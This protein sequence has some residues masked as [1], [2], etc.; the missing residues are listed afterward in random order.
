MPRFSYFP[1]SYYRRPTP[2]YSNNINFNKIT[3]PNLN[4]PI[5]PENHTDN[6]CKNTKKSPSK[7]KEDDC[8][9][10]IFGIKLFFDDILLL[11]LLYFLYTENV[12]DEGLFIVLFLLLIS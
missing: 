11:C 6:N 3:N 5:Q 8:L 4:H 7:T 10:E 1:Y 12:K 9:F 2:Y